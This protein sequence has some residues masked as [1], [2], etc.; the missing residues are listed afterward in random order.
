MTEKAANITGQYFVGARKM[1]KE[2]GKQKASINARSI[3]T[4]ILAISNPIGL[5]EFNTAGEA[6]VAGLTEEEFVSALKELCALFGWVWNEETWHLYIPSY[7]KW[8][9]PGNP[10]QMK[11]RMGFLSSVSDMDLFEKWVVSSREWIAKDPPGYHMWLEAAIEAKR[12]NIKGKKPAPAPAKAAK[13]KKEAK[14]DPFF[15]HFWNV[16][17]KKVARP[18]ALKA[19]VKLNPSQ[20]L[21][22]RVLLDV[23]SRSR[24]KGWT[25]DGRQFCPNPATYL[26]GRRWEDEAPAGPKLIGGE[27][28]GYKNG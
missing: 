25:K 11:F 1:H 17:P 2:L 6:K 18:A 26:N 27:F 3:S 20:K 23:Q 24:S 22:E 21:I 10:K 7:F 13:V 12:K 19:W 14:E 9:H 4:H 16:W 5:F 28:G 15:K 8:N